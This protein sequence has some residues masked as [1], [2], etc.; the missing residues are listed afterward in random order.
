VHT[1]SRLEDQALRR[2][3]GAEL[4]QG[5]RVRVLKDA[6]EN[7]PAWIEAIQSARK[8]VHFESYIIH[9]DRVG[10]EFAE[11]LM[12]K[13]REGVRIRLIYDWVGSL[14]NTSR[15]FWN[16]LARG[17]VDVRCFN[18]LK[19]ASPF[20]WVSRDHRKLI[21]V[22]G[23]VAFISGLCVGQLWVGYP[24]KGV[25]GWR[26]T[27]IEIEGPA[28]REIEGS[29]ADAWEATGD[30][31]PPSE[32]EPPELSTQP[33]NVDVRIVASIPNVG[34]IYRLD[35]LVATLA[36]RSIWLADAYFVG[37]TPYVQALRAA[38]QAGVDV[39]LLIPGTNDVPIMRSLS[40]SGL[41]P[42]LEAGIRVFEWN[43][44]MMHAKTAVSDGVLA[45]IGSTNLNV[46]SW[47][48]NWE[49]DVL[50]ED[51]RLAR[52]MEDDYLEDL[53]QSTEVT[54]QKRRR[55]QVVRTTTKSKERSARAS[56]PG[57]AAAGVMRIG[58]AV[59]A[60]ITNSRPLGPAEAVIMF[61][62]ALLLAGVSAVSILWPS[63]VIYPLV[64]F[65]IWFALSL[66]VRGFNL[67]FGKPRRRSRK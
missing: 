1:V 67:W 22:D 62:G 61:W 23:R 47:L 42:L 19:L 27:G 65:C 58:H 53:K 48:G 45:R 12:A 13:A 20:A 17:G 46:T 4:I 38:A 25:D 31:L 44:P 6:K 56:G 52:Q 30:P 41:R 36:R 28:L 50:I 59:E 64:T 7:Y 49:L 29:F 2:A 21:S 34:G 40:R 60:A 43:G 9:E 24:E 33:G 26:D 39:R 10:N 18:P 5:N 66:S 37:S 15:R 32:R 11:L 35:Q 55:L 8:W 63:V 51:K 16:R 14:G 57:R 54:L 3:T